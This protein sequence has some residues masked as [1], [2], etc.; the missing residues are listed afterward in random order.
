[1]LSPIIGSEDEA[2]GFDRIERLNV[3]RNIQNAG[4][5]SAIQ[6]VRAEKAVR[7]DMAK[8]SAKFSFDPSYTTSSRLS[9]CP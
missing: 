2:D 5:V 9:L 6:A 7:E 8:T 3:M 1:M 4:Y